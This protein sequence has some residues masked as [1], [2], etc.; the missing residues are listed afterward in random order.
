MDNLRKELGITDTD[1][2]S[3]TPSPTLSQEQLRTYNDEMM[4]GET[5]YNKFKEQYDQLK[6]LPP[7]QL[8]DVLPTITPGHRIVR[9]AG[10]IS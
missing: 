5:D 9:P 8:R 1:P 10:Q 2:Q 4:K 6:A 3:L 7:E